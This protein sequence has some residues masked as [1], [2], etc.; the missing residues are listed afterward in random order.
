MNDDVVTVSARIPA[1]IHAA[2]RERAQENRRSLN[3]ELV[4]ILEAAL[5]ERE[6]S[7]PRGTTAPS[8]SLSVRDTGALTAQNLTAH[9]VER[10]KALGGQNPP[11]R[12][13]GQVARLCGEMLKEGTD[14]EQV[15][16][17][18]DLLLEKRLHPSTLPSLVHEA[19]LP[20]ARAGR[21]GRVTPSDIMAR[22]EELRVMETQ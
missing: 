1:A 2:L 19:S 11:S 16:A 20:R 5:S 10:S 14:P 22:A 3:A 8:R 6:D 15:R 9:F 12:V 7:P 18:L 13:T 21:N 4:T 17:G